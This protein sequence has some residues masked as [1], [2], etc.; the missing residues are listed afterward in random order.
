MIYEIAFGSNPGPCCP[1]HDR[2]AEALRSMPSLAGMYQ[3]GQYRASMQDREAHR[4]RESLGVTEADRAPMPWMRLVTP[5]MPGGN[6]IAEPDVSSTLA[7]TLRDISE[8]QRTQAATLSDERAIRR[9]QAAQML[10]ARQ[11]SVNLHSQ[12][13]A[14]MPQPEQQPVDSNAEL[15]SICLEDL[16]LEKWSHDCNVNTCITRNALTIT[17]M[18]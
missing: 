6:V 2:P 15:C 8:V 18:H 16:P 1:N 17:R 12:D 10:A 4:D 9:Q 13:D 5:G 14:D 11:P 7:S 3:L